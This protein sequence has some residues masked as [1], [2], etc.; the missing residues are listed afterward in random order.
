MKGGRRS[1][2]SIVS[3]AHDGGCVNKTG[4]WSCETRGPGTQVSKGYEHGGMIEGVV[5]RDERR[6][7]KSL[8]LGLAVPMKADDAV[9][10]L[11]A[12]TST[13]KPVGQGLFLRTSH[14]DFF[15]ICIGI[16][17]LQHF[18]SYNQTISTTF[19]PYD[20]CSQI[21]MPRYHYRG[22]EME[23]YAESVIGNVNE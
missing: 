10:G 12:R 14:A 22:E 2:N 15:H 8:G 11:S 23:K 21:S 4:N 19:P 3:L 9:G 17:I 5:E 13:P 6:R 20:I 7:I 1:T 18:I 16:E